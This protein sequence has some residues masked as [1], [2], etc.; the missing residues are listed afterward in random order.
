MT[1]ATIEGFGKGFVER[2]YPLSDRGVPTLN[3]FYFG[4]GVGGPP[5]DNHLQH[6]MLLPGGTSTDVTPNADLAPST[7]PSGRVEL[8]FRD[9]DPSDDKD[10]Y[11]YRSSHVML[12]NR[13][14]RRFQFR[15]VGDSGTVRR[16]LPPEVF[17]R[18]PSPDIRRIFA[19]AGFKM[20]FTGNR[21]HHIDQLGVMLEDDGAITISF[22]DRNDD[23][24]FAYLIDLVRI[25]GVGMN[26]LPGE[27]SGSARG[28]ERVN[29]PR[30]VGMDFVIRGF[31]FDYASSDHHLRDVG[32]IRHNDRMDVFFGDKSGT[33]LFNWRVKWAHVGP[34]VVGL[35]NHSEVGDALLAQGG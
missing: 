5:V 7:I 30:P 9:D 17:G 32:V 34:M 29:I 22:N 19:L 15:D 12:D 6:I 31:H 20:F 14:A 3:S 25:S 27:S 26:I 16:P 21:D 10:E 4:Y 1:I 23:D 13:F 28:G 8:L 11:F 33:D 2:E 24:V 35:S 18:R